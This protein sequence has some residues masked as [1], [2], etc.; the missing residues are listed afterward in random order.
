MR[1]GF[2]D[3]LEAVLPGRVQFDC[4]LARYTSFGIG[5]AADALIEAGT[6][7]ELQLLLDT[8]QS[9]DVPWRVIGKGSNLLVSDDGFRGVIILLGS[10]FK[11]IQKV[12][13]DQTKRVTLR[14]GAGCSL[15][16]LNH[17]CWEEGLGGV[18]FSYGIPG[19]IGGATLMNAGAWGREI[20]ELIREVRLLGFTG[21]HTLSGDELDFCYRGWPG[22]GIYSKDWIIADIVLDVQEDDPEAIK[23]RSRELLQKRKLIQPHNMPSAGSFFRNPPGDSAGRLIDACGLKGRSVGGAM[24]SIQHANFFVNSGKATARDMLALMSEVQDMV[25]ARFGVKLEP[26]VELL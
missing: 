8:L 19:T 22:Y 25:K 9:E 11:K 16:K 24:V 13:R 4:P 5:G 2:K 17:Y 1:R 23:T 18:E 7:N 15:T 6:R 21:Y 12:K 3:R 14:A 20:G 26:E 10:E